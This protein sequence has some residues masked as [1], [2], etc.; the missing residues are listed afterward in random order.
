MAFVQRCVQRGQLSTD[1]LATRTAQRALCF[2]C[3]P[4]SSIWEV[5]FIPQCFYIHE[6]LCALSQAAVEEQRKGCL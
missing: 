3:C 1:H 2:L 5:W 6:F 4:V